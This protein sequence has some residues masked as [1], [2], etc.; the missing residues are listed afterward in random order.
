[1]KDPAQKLPVVEKVGYGVGDSELHL[2]LM[3]AR[4][5]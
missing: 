4:S 3:P 5:I 1:M 2:S